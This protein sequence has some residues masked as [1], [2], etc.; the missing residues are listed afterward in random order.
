MKKVTPESDIVVLKV[1]G[2]QLEPSVL[3]LL[4]QWAG[5]QSQKVNVVLVYG[6]GQQITHHYESNTQQKRP[7]GVQ[8]TTQ[9][10]LTQGVEP[11]YQNLTQKLKSTFPQAHFAPPK[12]LEC[13]YEDHPQKGFVGRPHYL[14]L[15]LEKP[16][17]AVGFMGQVE[18]QNVNVNADWIVSHIAQQWQSQIKSVIFCTQTSGILDTKGQVVSK[19]KSPDLKTILDHAH[20]TVQVSDGMRVKIKEFGPILDSGVKKIQLTSLVSL[21][22]GGI[23]TVIKN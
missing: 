6:G 18:G 1:S 14:N 23:K 17:S 2:N 20:P 10:I 8:K 7:P 13:H 3:P 21:V 5:H 12:S 19:L 9:E 15:P 16:L 11:A 22:E 4:E